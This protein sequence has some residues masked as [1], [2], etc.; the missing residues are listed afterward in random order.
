[1]AVCAGTGDVHSIQQR[2]VVRCSCTTERERSF[3]PPRSWPPFKPLDDYLRLE[4]H[5]RGHGEWGIEAKT[6]ERCFLSNV[7][8]TCFVKNKCDF[9]IFTFT[10][11]NSID[12]IPWSINIE[13]SCT[14]RL[15]IK[16]IE[17]W[18][19]DLNAFFCVPW[20][21]PSEWFVQ[22]F[23]KMIVY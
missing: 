12:N 15:K 18:N 3:L 17:R 14:M 7:H 19:F 23:L 16:R 2:C 22:C 5:D 9:W 11:N 8:V 13:S 1:M 20:Y 10:F 6:M 21:F 4:R